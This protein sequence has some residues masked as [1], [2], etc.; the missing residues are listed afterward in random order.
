MRENKSLA[1][2]NFHSE[3]EYQSKKTNTSPE[4]NT[5]FSYILNTKSAWKGAGEGEE[6]G[7]EGR[8]GEGNTHRRR[9]PDTGI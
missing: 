4:E 9:E 6:E 7:G 2:R 8:R 1:L 5:V 3:A